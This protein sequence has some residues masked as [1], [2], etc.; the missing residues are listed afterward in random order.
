[1]VCVCLCVFIFIPFCNSRQFILFAVFI[2]RIYAF[3]ETIN[4][5]SSKW[6]FV[7]FVMHTSS[8][9]KQMEPCT[10]APTINIRENRYQNAKWHRI[11]IKC[12][13]FYLCS[14][15]L[16]TWNGSKN[17]GDVPRWYICIMLS[18]LSSLAKTSQ[19]HDS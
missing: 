4:V 15:Y 16:S 17:Q 10:S 18:L 3:C 8:S 1:M 14:C 11:E 13:F 19:I 2:M 12:G 9:N 5:F 7:N 6:K